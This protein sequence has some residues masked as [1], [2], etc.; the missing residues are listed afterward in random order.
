MPE[1]METQMTNRKVNLV[2][3]SIKVQNIYFSLSIA[4]TENEII[5]NCLLLMMAGHDTTS[6]TIFHFIINLAIN[7]SKQEKLIEEIDRFIE[8]DELLFEKVK[9]MTYLEACLKETLRLHPSGTRAE[10]KAVDNVKLDQIFIPKDA[11]VV[12]PIYSI[13]RDPNN[14]ENPD[15]FI[16]ERFLAENIDKIKSGSYIPFADGPR[17]CVGMRF[18][19]MTIKLTLAKLLTEFRFVEC[20]KTRVLNILNNVFK[21]NNIIYI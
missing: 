9:R 20:D 1:V 11:Y 17:N 10:R 5:S 18:A 7:P 6:N 14:F 19:L 8:S 2:K 3:F 16:P 12:I 4:Q 13:H 15:E 21:N